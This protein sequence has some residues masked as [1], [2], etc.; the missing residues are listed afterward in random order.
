MS[1]RSVVLSLVPAVVL[2]GCKSTPPTATPEPAPAP[3]P[4]EDVPQASTATLPLPEAEAVLEKAVQAVGGRALVDGIES[5]Y[6]ESVMSVPAQNLTA[7][8]KLWWHEGRFHA[9]TEMPG[10]GVTRVW[11]DDKAIWAEDPINGRRQIEGIEARQTR[12][13]NAIVLAADWKRYFSAARTQTRRE[14][15]HG[16]LIDVVL[17]GD[18]GDEVVLSFDE[19]SGLLR[20][21]QFKQ[22]SPMGAMPVRL[23][24]HEYQ[25]LSGL[26]V[27]MRSVMD[28]GVMTAE[29]KLRKLQTNI[30]ITDDALRPE[31]VQ[32]PSP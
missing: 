14:T 27:A 9:V 24:F 17:T 20:E 10:V 8:S 12:W 15:E 13:G 25:E 7:S 18:D 23:E 26:L 3:A 2:W 32:P 19:T 6:L 1:L 11:G 31:G 4:A 21:Q 29:T 30:A 22:A 16:V 28:L 5:Y